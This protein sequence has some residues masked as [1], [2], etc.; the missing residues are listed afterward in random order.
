MQ[1]LRIKK[2]QQYAGF[3]FHSATTGQCE[4]GQFSHLGSTS[5]NISHWIY[6]TFLISVGR[7]PPNK[8][9]TSPEPCIHSDQYC[10]GALCIIARTMA[11]ALSA[12]TQSDTL[13]YPGLHKII[14]S[15]LDREMLTFS[16]HARWKGPIFPLRVDID[17]YI[18]LNLR[19]ISHQCRQIAPK[20]SA[21]ISRATHTFW[22]LLCGCIVHNSAYH[23]TR[24]EC[25]YAVWYAVISSST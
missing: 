7:L 19:H 15:I 24:F 4:K 3:T 12:H 14:V 18:P 16:H 2:T 23:G 22:S 25:A 5:I 9:H 6:N 11:H 8:A 10:V 13:W 17:Q 21:H 1:G 20:Q